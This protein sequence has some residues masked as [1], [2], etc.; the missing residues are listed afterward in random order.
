MA[1]K[2]AQKLHCFWILADCEQFVFIPYSM[3]K[4]KNIGPNTPVVYICKW[5]YRAHEYCVTSNHHNLYVSNS[6][7]ISRAQKIYKW[8]ETFKW[9]Q[10]FS[11]M[12]S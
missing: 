9:L 12:I 5:L 2:I 6:Y 10:H 7:I 3:N 4:C 1:A 8:V 11:K